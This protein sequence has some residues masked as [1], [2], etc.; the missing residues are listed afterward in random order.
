[1]KEA[2][3]RYFLLVCTFSEKSSRYRASERALTC[4]ILAA[5]FSNFDFDLNSVKQYLPFDSN[6][7][8]KLQCLL[9][10]LIQSSLLREMRSLKKVL[11]KEQKIDKGFKKT[12]NFCPDR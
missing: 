10:T 9:L 11:K 2:L 4:F 5:K 6:R 7:V 3:S 8:Q 1:M 12:F